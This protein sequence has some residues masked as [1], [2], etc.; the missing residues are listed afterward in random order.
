VCR[1]RDVALVARVATELWIPPILLSFGDPE[2]TV[3]EARI[4]GRKKVASRVELL[5]SDVP[6]TAAMARAALDLAGLAT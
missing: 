2:T 4:D 3:D 5:M 6:V 1:R